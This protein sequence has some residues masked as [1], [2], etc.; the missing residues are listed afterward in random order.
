[1]LQHSAE[2]EEGNPSAQTFLVETLLACDAGK[3]LL[4]TFYASCAHAVGCSL[5]TCRC[6]RHRDISGL[7][8][9][10]RFD[11][12]FVFYSLIITRFY[13]LRVGS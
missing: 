1:M 4:E 6:A 11:V 9:F 12:M 2:R 7:N 13:M 5:A 10:H 8:R 3:G